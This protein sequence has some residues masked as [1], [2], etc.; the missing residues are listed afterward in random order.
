MNKHICGYCENNEATWLYFPRNGGKTD[1]ACDDCVPRGCSC[2]IGLIGIDDDPP[3]DEN[4]KWHWI[5]ENQTWEYLDE[6]GRQWPCWEWQYKKN[7]FE[8]ENENI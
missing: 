3:Q 1:Y 6:K 7:G 8:I 2:N 4:S 5:K